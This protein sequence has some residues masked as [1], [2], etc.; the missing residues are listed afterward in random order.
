MDQDYWRTHYL[1]G[2]AEEVI[3]KIRHRIDACGGMEWVVLNPLSFEPE[4]LE[5]LAGEVMPGLRG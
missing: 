2:E 1:L 5:R 4:Q 3:E